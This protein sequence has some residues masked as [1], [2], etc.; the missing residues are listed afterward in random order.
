MGQGEVG[1]LIFYTYFD[2]PHLTFFETFI[3]K[4]IIF[5]FLITILYFLQLTFIEK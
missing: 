2:P 5:N 3:F 4:K 1:I